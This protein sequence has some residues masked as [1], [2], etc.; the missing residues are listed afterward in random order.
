MQAA[1]NSGS[2]VPSLIQLKPIPVPQAFRFTSN[3]FPKFILSTRQLVHPPLP[4]LL[5]PLWA[6][7]QKLHQVARKNIRKRE[8]DEGRS[9]V[10]ILLYY[11][12]MH[13]LLICTSGFVIDRLRHRS[14]G[15]CCEGPGQLGRG[16]SCAQTA[17]DACCSSKTFTSQVAKPVLMVSVWILA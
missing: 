15:T 4:R 10:F 16:H 1:S 5:D 12:Y 7:R 13:D 6:P 8:S 9:Y 17:K 11:D 2:N 14:A 3:P